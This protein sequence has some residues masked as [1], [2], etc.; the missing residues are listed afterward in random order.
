[1]PF[2]ANSPLDPF[3]VV[4]TF[5][6][7]PSAR[8]VAILTGG[9]TLPPY[10]IFPF[11]VGVLYRFAVD[12]HCI[13][14]VKLMA[15]FAKLSLLKVGSPLDTSVVGRANRV[16][17]SG[18]SFG[19]GRTNTLMLSH[20]T[21]GASNPLELQFRIKIRILRVSFFI[22]ICNRSNHTHLLAYRT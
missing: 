6:K 8:H 5:P 15:V 10:A 13:F 11:A 19:F 21:C 20:V 1:M 7:V 16:L 3:L 4:D 18:R 14:G 2:Y 22:P 12:Q 17:R 9:L